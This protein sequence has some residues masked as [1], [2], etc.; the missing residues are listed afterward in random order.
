MTEKLNLENI[1]YHSDEDPSNAWI[2]ESSKKLS[3]NHRQ[4]IIILL[5]YRLSFQL[6]IIN[7]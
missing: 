7:I 6:K 3:N 2:K 5:K 4:I 1:F